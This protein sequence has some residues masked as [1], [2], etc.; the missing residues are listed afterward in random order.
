MHVYDAGPEAFG[1]ATNAI[2]DVC[3]GVTWL[4]S[5]MPLL[6]CVCEVHHSRVLNAMF[7]AWLVHD[8]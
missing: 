3:G 4:G 8:S 5:C 1:G 2:D 6:A 7:T